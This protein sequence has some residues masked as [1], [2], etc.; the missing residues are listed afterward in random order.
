MFTPTPLV[1]STSDESSGDVLLEQIFEGLIEEDEVVQQT[2]RVLHGNV[3]WKL[4]LE[5]HQHFSGSFAT[6]WMILIYV[7]VC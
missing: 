2:G 4:V 7:P 6:L 3:I 5:H 1:D